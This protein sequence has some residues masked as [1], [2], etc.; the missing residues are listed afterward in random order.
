MKVMKTIFDNWT[1][2]VDSFP[3]PKPFENLS[4]EQ[5]TVDT[6]T[7]KYTTDKTYG[8]TGK[9][10]CRAHTSCAVAFMNYVRLAQGKDASLSIG[11]IDTPDGKRYIAS[12]EYTDNVDNTNMQEIAIW[13]PNPNSD[14]SA[15]KACVID[16]D[17]NVHNAKYSANNHNILGIAMF[18]AMIPEI[19]KEK[20]ANDAFERFKEI[21]L[22]SNASLI[23]TAYLL[24]AVYC[25]NVYRRVM[26]Q[27]DEF[28]LNAQIV[29]GN[30]DPITETALRHYEI[31]MI[32]GKKFDF[33]EEKKT[34]VESKNDFSTLRTLYGDPDEKWNPKELSMIP[35]IDNVE[36]SDEAIYAA[37]LFR[38]AEK[39]GIAQNNFGFM[40]EAGSGKSTDAMAIAAILNKPFLV[41]SISSNTDE[42]N[43]KAGIYPVFSVQDE[44]GNLQDGFK[45]RGKKWSD[46]TTLEE[47][48]FDPETAYEKLTGSRVENVTAQDVMEWILLNGADREEN[49]YV[50]MLS[51]LVEALTKGYVV[52]VQEVNLCN[53]PAVMPII[54][55]F[56]ERGTI[57]M[58]NGQ[59]L[60]RDP[61]GIAIFTMNIDYAGCNQMN[62]SVMSRLH[63]KAIKNTPS[64]KE[65]VKRLFTEVTIE[66]N[67]NI[68]DEANKMAKIVVEI[69]DYC[70]TKGF[71]DGVCGYREFKNWFITTQILGV[72][73]HAAAKNTIIPTATL[74][75]NAQ[76]E[77]VTGV[78]E[79]YYREDIAPTASKRR[80]RRSNK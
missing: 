39:L 58:D 13:N 26:G 4:K 55:E 51:P 63:W 53:D 42:T 15:F 70:K 36:I 65:M 9:K 37:K 38:N 72:S 57:R 27:A 40:G 60:K 50:Y 30:L 75:L 78:L 25:D 66:S 52:E 62:A 14:E 20:E 47:I 18:A 59:T 22:D 76:N 11:S 29:S 12:V 61:S 54:N 7:S 64:A 41:L 31:D 73:P 2:S 43:I 56:L 45:S 69:N 8:K 21:E 48:T 77:L 23:K 32:A 34:S 49:K 35:N 79:K 3:M 74:D 19:M 1:W 6:V 80:G 67:D 71:N 46:V 5:L 68:R 10:T 33:I 17:G 24:L 28:N 44:D 16:E